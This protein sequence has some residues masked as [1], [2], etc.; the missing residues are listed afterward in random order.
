MS[1]TILLISNDRIQIDIAEAFENIGLNIRI[2]FFRAAIS[3][4]VSNRLED[5]VPSVWQVVQV[6]VK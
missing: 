6:S 3:C 5:V 1:H 2:D 4:F